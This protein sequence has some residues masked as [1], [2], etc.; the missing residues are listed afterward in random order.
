MVTETGTHQHAAHVIGFV[1]LIYHAPN[2]CVKT[3]GL[4]MRHHVSN[5]VLE[6]GDLSRRHCSYASLY[7]SLLCSAL[8]Y[9]SL[10]CLRPL[11]MV[12]PKRQ[13]AHQTLT[14]VPCLSRRLTHSRAPASAAKCSG[15]RRSCFTRNRC[16]QV[17]SEAKSGQYKG[18]NKKEQSQRTT[19]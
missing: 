6:L 11:R 12:P 15:V 3:G 8:S 18:E 14:R 4:Q 7:S 16:R 2:P 13:A 19:R 10:L 1:I 17:P 5:W 9:L